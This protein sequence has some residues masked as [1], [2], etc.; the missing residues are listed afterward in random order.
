M[1]RLCLFGD[2]KVDLRRVLRRRPRTTGAI[3]DA[4]DD[5]LAAKPR[6]MSGFAGFA[7]RSVGG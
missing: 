7:M 3:D 5:A 2:E 1:L 4:I 6:R